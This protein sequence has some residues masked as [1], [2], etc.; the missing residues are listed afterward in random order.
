MPKRKRGEDEASSLD[1]HSDVE[2]NSD[3]G[4]APAP[5]PTVDIK[6][7]S[8]K[9]HHHLRVLRATIKRARTF[10]TQRIVKRLKSK[11]SSD[12]EERDELEAEL[13]VLKN[14]VPRTISARALLTKC[15]KQRLLPPKG[16][17]IPAL[18]A[19][20]AEELSAECSGFPLL[21]ALQTKGD[22]PAIY[23]SLRQESASSSQSARSKAEEKVHA[24]L[25]SSKMLAE[26]IGKVVQELQRIIHPDRAAPLKKADGK[27]E[28][29]PADAD[30]VA[31]QTKKGRNKAV[32]SEGPAKKTSP[33]AAPKEA[34]PQRRKA[35][36]DNDS[37][38]DEEPETS[39]DDMELDLEGADLDASDFDDEGNE[40]VNSDIFNEDDNGLSGDE[41]DSG[42]D[43]EMAEKSHNL[44][45]LAGGFVT[46]G[47]SFR[48]RGSD[49]D[50]S[51]GS[52]DED[53]YGDGDDIDE[54]AEENAAVG[55]DG[56][57]KSAKKQA[58]R[59]N[60]MGQRARQAIWE[61][62]Y[63]RNARHIAILKREPRSQ[64][65]EG[66]G[67]GTR[68][69]GFGLSGRG[70]GGRAAPPGHSSAA[71]LQRD[72]GWASAREGQSL[73]PQPRSSAPPGRF[74]SRGTAHHTSAPPRPPHGGAAARTGDGAPAKAA[75]S[76]MAATT[77]HP[78]WVAK[79]KQK[80]QL[81]Q[82]FNVKPVGKKVVF[83]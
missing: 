77:P 49:S 13:A 46:R 8:S 38:D 47:L 72:R 22:L 41:Q 32:S 59:K 56:K 83:D 33:T 66:Q 74:A 21:L 16:R 11:G 26:E 62:K 69:R 75:S 50:Y 70:R 39:D 51:G 81:S 1:S 42:D 10:E 78:S 37:D 76:A 35:P 29:R 34:N 48:D 3:A 53:D 12:D 67:A 30:G 28:K 17:P 68:G 54:N 55:A 7:L 15:T 40:D 23:E 58:K 27:S 52:D 4:E 71:T 36:D 44:P 60:R 61:K 24:R 2:S 43:D 82:A 31:E 9:L 18:S 63:G 64:T 65:Q 79:Q 80:E 14:I 45:S 6:K 25:T 5:H 73:G 20:S 57:K 19:A